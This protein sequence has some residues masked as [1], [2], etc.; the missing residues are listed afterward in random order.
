MS[1]EF[2]TSES[3]KRMLEL[4]PKYYELSRVFTASCQ[5]IGSEL[6]ELWQAIQDV[7]D[8]IFVSTAT[9]GLDQWEKMLGLP[10]YSGKPDDHRRSR[11]ISKLRGIGTVTVEL[12]KNVAESY[13]NGAVEV[14]NYPEEYRFT[15]KFVDARGVPPNLDDLKEAIEEIKPAHLAVEYRFTYTVWSELPQWGITWGQ[16]VQQGLTW[17]ELKTWSP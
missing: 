1:D 15:V 4:C 16:I 8:Q 10:T 9:W 7:L 12:I 5:A 6:D 13:V 11:I 2:L 3:G 14:E 17:E